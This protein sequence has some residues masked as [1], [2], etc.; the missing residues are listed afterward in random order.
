MKKYLKKL[1]N[2]LLILLA[3]LIVLDAA[4]FIARRQMRKTDHE[5][6][7]NADL[8]DAILYTV[9]DGELQYNVICYGDVTD[10]V[11]MDASGNGIDSLPEL[12]DILGKADAPAAVPDEKSGQRTL[13]KAVT[14]DITTD[15]KG[16]I[17][18]VTVK[19]VSER[20]VIG[21]SWKMDNIG[22][23]YQG[24]A[25]AFERNGA[26][27]VYLP[28][29][30]SEDHAKM[31]LAELDGIFVTG[32]EDW[33]PAL[34]GQEPIPHGSVDC[35]DIRDLSDLNLIRKALEL[36]IPMLCICRGAQ[37]LNIALGGGLIQDVPSYL[38]SLGAGEEIPEGC[39]C[40][41]KH[42][43]VQAE[44]IVHHGNTYHPLSF[45][46][47][48]SKWLWEIFGTE[49]LPLVSTAHHQAIDP[50]R[51][52]AGLTVAAKSADG[53][54][55]AVEYRENRFVLGLQW[56]PE[57]DALEDTQSTGIDR[58]HSNLP[59]RALVEHAGES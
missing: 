28:L 31:V 24:F 59:L 12:T 54:I 7:K 33:N 52:G 20:P 29:V 22:S 27:A 19:T 16:R 32:G 18:N 55:E 49:S 4:R 1:G 35:N 10:A 42:L 51:L 14:A 40:E 15:S 21:I 41:E 25:E 36:D 9:E 11:I 8:T 53:I 44:G 13:G 34:Y 57:R 45:I 6:L 2:I 3:V 46:D 39:T 17:T 23:D 48:A 30:I 56:H 47:P 37:G 38:G 5:L 43:R 50:E 58:H 26:L